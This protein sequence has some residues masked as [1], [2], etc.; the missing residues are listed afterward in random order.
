MGSASGVWAVV[1]GWAGIAAL[2]ALVLS[3]FWA[4]LGG[5]FIFDDYPNLVDDPAWKLLHL[6]FPGLMQVWQSGISSPAGRPLAMLSFAFSHALGGGD[7]WSLKLGGLL[8][9]VF[10][11]CLAA[12]LLRR[13][14][15]LAGERA[16][17]GPYW[18]AFLAAA[19]WA[20]HP[21]Q[22]SSVLY[23]VQRM[24]VGAASGVLLGLLAY[25]R[26][27][28]ALC[29]DERFWPWALLAVA[30][31]L[32]GLGFKETAVLLPLY[33]LWL[34]LLLLR[35]KGRDGEP[36]AWL[37]ALY[38]GGA[39]LAVVAYCLWMVPEYAGVERFFGRNFGT[40]ERL[41]SQGPILLMYLQQA[42]SAWPELLHFYYDDYPVS[43][44]LLAPVMTL[45]AWLGLAALAFS[46]LWAGRRLP[47]YSLGICWFF[48]AH[49]LS[50]N[51]LPLELAFEHRNYFAL[52]GLV[53]AALTIA[54]AVGRRLTVGAGPTLAV[55]LVVYVAVMGMVQVLTWSEPTRLAL[56][57]SSRAPNS[58]RAS[59]E[60]GKQLY[61]LSAGDADAPLWT[62]AREEFVRAAAL[63]DSSPLSEQ[64]ILIMDAKAGRP[65]DPA[66]WK[67]L[68]Y[69]VASRDMGVQVLA[70]VEGVVQCRTSGE[71]RFDDDAQLQQ[72]LVIALDRNPQS[73]RL[74]ARYAE[75]AFSVMGDDALARNLLHEAIRL[76]P[77]QPVFHLLLARILIAAGD[78][79]EELDG[80]ELFAAL[81]RAQQLDVHGEHAEEIQR[82]RS[83][84]VSN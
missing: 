50:S 44:G 80:R 66:M 61:G 41:L 43:S 77:E 58:E 10:N 84:V 26:A 83:A 12:L 20:L 16:R 27:R 14:L 9:H 56:T 46:A 62:L 19:I 29:A 48:S 18:A 25:L 53:L 3:M 51:I 23:V 8:L 74:H 60:L 54:L 71:C 34:E 28:Q 64:A 38:A 47:L 82:L 45:W 1:R 22:V 73:A 11:A 76:D 72:V 13:L 59:Y 15:V 78:S 24:E 35:F 55:V 17:I 81:Q 40:T 68:Q 33:A 52:L 65:D 31:G 75:F 63:P 5:G 37:V 79:S 67:G 57:L 42:L 36:M 2:A 32:L 30:A 70:A 6:D 69:K 4:G 7:V 49:L 39:V 21:L